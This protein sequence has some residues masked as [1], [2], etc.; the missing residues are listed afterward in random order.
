MQ[1]SLKFYM[2]ADNI[3]TKRSSPISIGEHKDISYKTLE[4]L[5]QCSY[6]VINYYFLHK[7]HPIEGKNFNILNFERKS[8]LHSLNYIFTKY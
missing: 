8:Y 2:C 1:N 5:Q 7:N 3:K 4:H 6:F